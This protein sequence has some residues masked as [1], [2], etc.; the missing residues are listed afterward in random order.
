MSTRISTFYANA[1]APRRKAYR[2]SRPQVNLATMMP[3][4]FGACRASRKPVLGD[5]LHC[6]ALPGSLSGSGAGGVVLGGGMARFVNPYTFVPHVPEPQRG[7]P[8]G[9]DA[10][11]SGRL[12][13]VLKVTLTARTPLL[14]GGFTRQGPGGTSEHDVPRRLDGTVIV[15][16]SGLM[17]AVRSVHEALAGGCLRV[18]DGDR[19]PVH[20]HPANTSETKD[21]RLAVV[22][23]VDA[24]GRAVQVALC[25]E[26]IWIPKELLPRDEDRLSRTGDQLQYRSANGRPGLPPGAAMAGAGTRRVLLAKS[27]KHPQGVSLGSI[28][29]I[30][31]LGA[32]AGEC[33]VLLVTDTNARAADRPAYFAAGRIGPAAMSCPVPQQTWDGFQDV[34]AGA[35]DLRR[36]RLVKAGFADGEEPAWGTCPPEYEDV[37]WPPQDSGDGRGERRRIAQ[38][39]RARTYLH[40]GQPVWVRIS[41]DDRS[42]TE[43][44]LSQLW[45]YQGQIPV[46]E[47]VGSAGPCTD[48]K[49][50]LCW[51]CRVFGSADTAGREADDLA[52]QNSYRGHVRVDDLLAEGNVE[53]VSW[54]L[55]PL[56]SPRPG[57]GQFYLDHKAVPPAGRVARKDTRPAATWGSEADTPARRPLRGRKFYWR[58]T[59]PTREPFPRG[60]YRDHQSDELSSK[61]ALI[62]AGS[63]FTGRV[64]FDNLS[65][66]DYGSLLVALD[67]RLM[68][69]AEA[70]TWEGV[71][72]SVGG[73]KPFGFGAVTIDVERVLVQT[74]RA[75]YLGEAAHVADEAEAVRAFRDDVPQSVSATWQALRHALTFGFV[76]D[77]LV[78]YPPGPDGAKG[79]EDFDKSFEFF[80]RTVGL[81]LKDKIRDLVELPDAAASPSAQ[82]LDSRAGERRKEPGP[83]DRDRGRRQR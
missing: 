41:G 2:Y 55:A 5:C 31:E 45:R 27:D 70:A 13:G 34:V 20:R 3:V 68:A 21:L 12:S 59:D 19:V 24:A 42:V 26:W 65:L 39:L 67:P 52:V 1:K 22:T 54:H 69:E 71:V 16:A 30:G 10:M 15:P 43:I 56:A 77:D 11:G 63:V 51:S 25:D 44:R 29:R 7:R 73:G 32:V 53:P 18:L 74:A 35:D 57:A 47:R 48:L 79:S 76:S 9:H 50:N 40:P 58:T 36:A 81:E 4:L 17:G 61:V 38:R 64:A 60:R 14:I 8:A 46:G 62:P 37:W 80:P 72:T 75:R 82:V 6:A 23:G 28:V 33:W 49:K 83:A 78:W 66:A